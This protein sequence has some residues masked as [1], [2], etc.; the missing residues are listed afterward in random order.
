MSGARAPGPDPVENWAATPDRLTLIEAIGLARRTAAQLTEL[1]VDG[2]AESGR[3]ADGGWRVLVDVV[4]SAARM[5]EN[6]L[7]AT[8]EVI[9]SPEGDLTG[10]SRLRRYHREDG[11]T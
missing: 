10:F 2:I 1:P 8:H 3:H 4:E 5:G 7:L 11:A 9:L 6:D